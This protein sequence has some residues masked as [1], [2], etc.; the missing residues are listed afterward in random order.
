MGSFALCGVFP[1]RCFRKGVVPVCSV[2]L[3][4]CCSDGVLSPWVHGTPVVLCVTFAPLPGVE[5]ASAVFPLGLIPSPNGK[6]A[7][8]LSTPGRG[9]KVT[10]RTTG[11]PCTRGLRPPSQQQQ[12]KTTE[13][14][15]TTPFLKHR[16]GKTPH[17]AKLPI[18]KHSQHQ[19]RGQGR[20]ATKREHHVALGSQST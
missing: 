2:V 5:S 9:V 4:C 10:H 20:E 1:L 11:V 16:K 6:T 3:P 15:G 7:K 8:A 18:H 19:A 13:N 14:T 17:K 12:G